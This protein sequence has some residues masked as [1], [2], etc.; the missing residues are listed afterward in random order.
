MKP[1][2]T[3]LALALIFAQPGA[4]G[5]AETPGAGG[6]GAAA[7]LSLALPDPVR[8]P[9]S[10]RMLAG[11]WVPSDPGA[12]DFS[13]L[14][15]IPVEHAVVSDVSARKG[16]NQHNYLA[17][18]AGRFWAMWSDG[19]RIEDFAGQV[20]KY[21][22]SLDGLAWTEPKMLTGYPPQSGP[23]SPHY[24]TR[25]KE[26]FRYFARGFWVREGQLLAL[27]AMDDTGG[28]FG[29][30]L[31]LRALRWNESEK[32][33]DEAGIVQSNAINNFPPQR[34]PN[35]AWAMTRRKHDYQTSGVELLIGGVERM[36]RWISHPVVRGGVSDSALKAEEP[37]WYALPSGH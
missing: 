34:L 23:D 27:V 18:F 12:I 19:P 3:F 31:E 11:A 37:I 13:R 20:V 10:S 15:R 30:K 5:A 1:Q 7:S 4:A 8:N 2:P 35:G 21:S 29:E 14:P 25:D 33:W 6:L 26:G 9:G 22:T 36:D 17:H 28:F 32:T 16:V 24:N